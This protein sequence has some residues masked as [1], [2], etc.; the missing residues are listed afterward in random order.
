MHAP[1]PQQPIHLAQPERR[2]V[3]ARLA[4]LRAGGGGGHV[5]GEVGKG[6]DGGAQP[7][8][9]QRALLA[10]VVPARQAHGLEQRLQAAGA[11]D[12]GQAQWS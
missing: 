12:V 8:V 6:A 3:D 11:Q 10:K 5:G 7:R 9:L 1:R 4:A 2:P